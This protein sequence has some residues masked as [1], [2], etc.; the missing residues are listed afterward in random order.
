MG[1]SR[2]L[3]ALVKIMSAEAG[4]APSPGPPDEVSVRRK[5]R[6]VVVCVPQPPSGARR[7]GEGASLP[8]R[9]SKT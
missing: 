2:H 7:W 9:T 6:L 5:E 3:V 1:S 8:Q 4:E